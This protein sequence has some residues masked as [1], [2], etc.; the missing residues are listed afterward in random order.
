MKADFRSFGILPVSKD[1]RK[2]LESIL[3]IGTFPFFMIK[4]ETPSGPQEAPPG[5]ESIARLKS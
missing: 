4:A 3:A 1:V 2:I 5:I